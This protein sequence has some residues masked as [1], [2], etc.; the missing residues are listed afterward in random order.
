M[1]LVLYVLVLCVAFMLL[2]IYVV[3]TSP[4]I[5]LMDPHAA[6]K[7]VNDLPHPPTLSTRPGGV[8]T[9]PIKRST[10]WMGLVNGAGHKLYTKIWGFEYNH[11]VI[12]PGP[13]IVA[14][15][16]T[17]FN[18]FFPNELR[19]GPHLFPVDTTIDIATGYDG[20]GQLPVVI[21][22]HGGHNEWQS[23]GHPL[24]WY[25]QAYAKTGPMFTKQNYLYDN[26]QDAT[27]LW[28][29]DH[30]MGLTRL[31]NQ[32]GLFGMYTVTDTNERQLVSN[33]VLPDEDHTLHLAIGDRLFTTA[34]QQYFPGVHGEPVNGVDIESGWPNPSQ[35]HEFWGN[36]VVVNG[37]TWPKQAV[38]PCAYRLRILNA[39]D[40]RTFILSFSSNVRFHMVGT[41]G[42]FMA[43]PVTMRSLV[44]MPAQRADLVVD[45]SACAGM[46][47][48]LHNGG[49]DVPFKGFTN[50]KLL[51]DGEGGVVQPTDARTTGKIMM[52]DVCAHASHVREFNPNVS[53]VRWPKYVGDVARTRQLCLFKGTDEY[54]R[55]ILMLGT[56]R[57]GSLFWSDPPTEVVQNHTTE[58]WE[59]Y[60]TT[61]S[62]HPIHL[63]LVEFRVLNR[64]RFEGTATERKQRNPHNGN[65][66][67]GQLLKT[68]KPVGSLV[69]PE[70]A[71]QG[72][73]DT[74]FVPPQQVTRI[75]AHF[76]RPGN[77]VWHCHLLSH[78]D[79]EMMRPLIVV[80]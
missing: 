22:L 32:A 54:D 73:M 72:P 28:Y 80:P 12:S 43:A 39:A 74:V 29:H 61:V 18:V 69:A 51:S 4:S 8:Y 2:T 55:N 60:N 24:A 37:M 57:D 78:E 38:E 48:M 70:L 5:T 21:H 1:R 3:W 67:R 16:D 49:P 71:E 7:F 35:L 77:Y 26:T 68:A 45:F 53:L 58:V 46:Q 34:G 76:D 13:T 79:N 14:R 6:P 44:L 15:R 10:T 19:P 27:L 64:Q 31:N 47:V 59:I 50:T 20:N 23:D 25:T 52:F 56:L 30:T 75:I 36:F 62:G 66:I 11:Q 33:G 63:H 9:L 42:G 40:T 65:M 17:A 41:D